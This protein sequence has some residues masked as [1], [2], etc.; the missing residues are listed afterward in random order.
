VHTRAQIEAA[1]NVF[2]QHYHEARVDVWVHNPAVTDPEHAADMDSISAFMFSFIRATHLL[3]IGLDD[4][5]GLLDHGK[6]LK[7]LGAGIAT[8]AAAAVTPTAPASE[9]V[10]QRSCAAR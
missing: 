4:M 1:L 7:P 2:L 8:A 10:S 6:Q 9:P 3:I 5:T